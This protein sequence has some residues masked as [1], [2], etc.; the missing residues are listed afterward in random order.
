M[1]QTILHMFDYRN[2]CML[3]F[4]ISFNLSINSLS[5]NYK[6][7][8]GFFLWKLVLCWYDQQ[9]M[10]TLPLHLLEGEKLFGIKRILASIDALHANISQFTSNSIYLSFT[11]IGILLSHRLLTLP[12]YMD[13]H[14]GDLDVL[15]WTYISPC[16]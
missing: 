8:F 10:I 1:C 11:L 15:S 4:I 14:V 6:T 9:W 2:C 3:A 7:F 13:R 16:R 5:C 12:L